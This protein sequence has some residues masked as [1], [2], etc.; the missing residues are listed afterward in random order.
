MLNFLNSISGEVPRKGNQRLFLPK[1]DW[2]LNGS[3]TLTVTYN[4]LRWNSPGIQTQAIILARAI[5]LAM[6]L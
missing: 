6:T 5:T 2:H 1:V 3:N 4:N